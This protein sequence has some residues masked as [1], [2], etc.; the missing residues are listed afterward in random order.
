MDPATIMTVAALVFR[1]GKEIVPFIKS[2]E[3]LLPFA[4]KLIGLTRGEH[5]TQ[6]DLDILNELINA[7]NAEIQKPLEN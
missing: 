2:A 7:K 3:E 4:E 6:Q 5:Y 1:V